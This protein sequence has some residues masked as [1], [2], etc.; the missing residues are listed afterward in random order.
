MGRPFQ[1][2]QELENREQKIPSQSL[3]LHLELRGT[4]LA[5][6]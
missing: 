3:C 4:F 6:A 2:F 1:M 5:D